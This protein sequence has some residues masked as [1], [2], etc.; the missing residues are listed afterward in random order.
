MYGMKATNEVMIFPGG[1]TAG[2]SRPRG[3]SENRYDR[4]NHS[5]GTWPNGRRP[6]DRVTVIA[7]PKAKH[8]DREENAAGWLEWEGYKGFLPQPT[9]LAIKKNLASLVQSTK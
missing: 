4:T 3:N 1:P 9:T 7:T 5:R 6:R 2:T 8:L